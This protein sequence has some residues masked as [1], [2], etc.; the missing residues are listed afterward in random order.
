MSDSV[1]SPE[2]KRDRLYTLFG[3]GLG[4]IIG[5]SMIGTETTSEWFPFALGAVFIAGAYVRLKWL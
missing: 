2:S 5:A 3:L 4:L 1:E